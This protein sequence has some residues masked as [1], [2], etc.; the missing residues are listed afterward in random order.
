MTAHGS[1]RRGERAMNWPE[2]YRRLE[3]VQQV[4]AGGTEATREQRAEILRRRAAGLARAPTPVAVDEDG[5]NVTLVEFRLSRERYAVEAAWVGEVLP[6]RHLTELPCVPPFVAGIIN[7]R[8]HIM[9]VIDLRRFFDLPREGLSD[10]SRVVVLRASTEVAILADAVLGARS[11]ALRDLQPGLPTLT[12]I[13]EEFLKGVAD[14]GIVILD[15]E[16]LLADVKLIVNEDV[17]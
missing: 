8:G 14:E 15:A 3:A 10:T 17:A 6:L 7:V 11:M 12:G 13:R 9:P 5:L 4:L 1:Q 2:V 16:R